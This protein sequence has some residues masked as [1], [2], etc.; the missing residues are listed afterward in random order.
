MTKNHPYNYPQYA[1][2]KDPITISETILTKAG[3]VLHTP[4]W[5]FST[6][7][8]RRNEINDYNLIS[9]NSTYCCLLHSSAK[10]IKRFFIVTITLSRY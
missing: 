2:T 1:T 10:K 5:I 9:E 8:V 6:I 3:Y 7:T 4:I